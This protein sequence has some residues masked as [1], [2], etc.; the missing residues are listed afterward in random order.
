MTFQN[1]GSFTSSGSIRVNGI[2]HKSEDR[3]KVGKLGDDIG[4]IR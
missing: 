1:R 3:K 2:N 4:A